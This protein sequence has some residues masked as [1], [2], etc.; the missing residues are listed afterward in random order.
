MKGDPAKLGS[1]SK[2]KPTWTITAA[3]DLVH[4]GFFFGKEGSCSEVAAKRWTAL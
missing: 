3:A 2:S 1:Q 4:V